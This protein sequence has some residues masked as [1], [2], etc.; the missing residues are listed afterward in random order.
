VITRAILRRKVTPAG[1][2]VGHKIPDIQNI[3]RIF[4]TI[5]SQDERYE[6]NLYIVQP[7]DDPASGAGEEGSRTT[8]DGESVAAGTPQHGSAASTPPERSPNT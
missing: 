7:D 8:A 5:E 4:D 1:A 3:R 2:L 6:L